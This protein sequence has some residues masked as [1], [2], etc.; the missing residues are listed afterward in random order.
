MT[1][2]ED[3]I[4]YLEIDK[5]IEEGIEEAVKNSVLDDMDDGYEQWKEQN[6]H[7]LGIRCPTCQRSYN[8]IHFECSEYIDV[9]SCPDNAKDNAYYCF[10]CDILWDQETGEVVEDFSTETGSGNSLFDADDHSNESYS[11]QTNPNIYDAAFQSAVSAGLN[12][13]QKGIISLPKNNTG[14]TTKANWAK[15][16][17]HKHDEI[18]LYD[19]TSI[20][21]SSV[22]VADPENKPDFGLYADYIWSPTWR[23]EFINW[24]DYGI[25]KDTAMS[26]VQIYE[27][28]YRATQ[29]NM[30]EIGCIGGHGRTGTILAVMQ[31]AASNGAVTAD[32]AIKFVRKEYCDHAIESAVQEWYIAYSAAYWW[33][34]DLP[35]KPVVTAGNFNAICQ[36]NEHF[37]MILRGHTSCAN[38]KDGNCQYWKKDLEDFYS[39]K[40]DQQQEVAYKNALQKAKNYDYIYGGELKLDSDPGEY[41]CDILDHYVMIIQGH[42]DECLRLGDKCKHWG[43]DITEWKKHNTIMSNSEWDK[44]SVDRLLKVYPAVEEL[45]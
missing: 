39:D 43:D 33:G 44:D 11:Y 36:R 23:N 3:F 26:L 42:E 7:M 40:Y 2:S 20:F 15:T 25:P 27:A 5:G 9:C 31:I 22:R 24:P 38:T 29:G 12:S 13:S 45:E 37:A 17:S 30:V 6:L 16:C 18:K 41:P 28:Y 35:E 14:G 21:C 10:E 1:I 34:H 4:D 8:I 32:E 19:G